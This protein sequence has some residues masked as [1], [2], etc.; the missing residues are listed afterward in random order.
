MVFGFTVKKLYKT[1]Q[2]YLFFE[3]QKNIYFCKLFEC[4]CSS[5]P[6]YSTDFL[7]PNE[8]NK[9]KKRKRTIK[10]AHEEP[11]QSHLSLK[12]ENPFECVV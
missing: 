3:K 6:Q 10:Y 11:S 7:P 9:E 5:Q 2:T 12:K 4:R 1:N 8:M